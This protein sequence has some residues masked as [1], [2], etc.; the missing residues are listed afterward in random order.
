MH[1]SAS[2]KAGLDI[3]LASPKEAAAAGGSGSQGH[4]HETWSSTGRHC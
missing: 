3:E 2:P 1:S 4:K